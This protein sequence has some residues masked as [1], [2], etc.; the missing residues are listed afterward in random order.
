MEMELYYR[1]F[2]INTCKKLNRL[3]TRATDK[4]MEKNKR[5]ERKENE[6]NKTRNKTEKE[7]INNMIWR[8]G[9]WNVKSL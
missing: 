2:R 1:K 5:M 4:A 8:C 6:T 7:K 9:T 3:D